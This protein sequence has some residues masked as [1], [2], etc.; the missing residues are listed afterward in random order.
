M[1]SMLHLLQKLQEVALSWLMSAS[2]G[3]LLLLVAEDEGRPKLS[4]PSVLAYSMNMRHI[5]NHAQP[6]P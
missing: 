1:N 3:S 5:N 6:M 2:A 4:D